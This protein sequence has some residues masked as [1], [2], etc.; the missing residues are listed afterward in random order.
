MK[1]LIWRKKVAALRKELAFFARIA[2]N[3]PKTL[4]PGFFPGHRNGIS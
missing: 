4:A 1:D 3:H 2:R